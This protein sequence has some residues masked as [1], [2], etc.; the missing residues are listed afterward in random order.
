MLQCNNLMKPDIGGKADRQT[1]ELW[2]CFCHVAVLFCCA[3][4][5]HSVWN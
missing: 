4:L 2:S 3:L 5:A 1:A